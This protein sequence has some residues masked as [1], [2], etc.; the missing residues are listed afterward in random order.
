[1]EGTA[2]PA[3]VPLRPRL[4][5]LSPSNRKSAV[6]VLENAAAEMDEMPRDAAAHSRAASL[7]FSQDLKTKSEAG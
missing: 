6:G 1:M 5:Q 3:V 2:K 7:A 4:V